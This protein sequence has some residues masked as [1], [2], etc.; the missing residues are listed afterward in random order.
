MNRLHHSSVT[1]ALATALVA[2]IGSEVA[3]VA[4][5]LEKSPSEVGAWMRQLRLEEQREAVLTEHLAFFTSTYEVREQTLRDFLAGRRTFLETAACFRDLNRQS[6]VGQAHEGVSSSEE[7]EACRQVIRW[8]Y[9][10]LAE[11]STDEAEAR[12]AALERE[13]GGQLDCF[14]AVLFPE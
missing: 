8:T 9:S 1:V 4:A 14:G 11:K 5:A 3:D 13:L 10:S 7:E 2:V 6:P 12:A